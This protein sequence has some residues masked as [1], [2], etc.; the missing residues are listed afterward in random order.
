VSI[1]LIATIGGHLNSR[2]PDGASEQSM[3]DLAG[4]IGFRSAWSYTAGCHFDGMHK[5]LTESSQSIHFE[6]CE[7]LSQ[8]LNQAGHLSSTLGVA[9]TQNA[10]RAAE[11]CDEFGMWLLPFPLLEL[12]A[13]SEG[14][15]FEHLDG[16]DGVRGEQSSVI[17]DEDAGLAT[18]DLTAGQIG[19]GGDPR[20]GR[21]ILQQDCIGLLRP[22]QLSEHF[23][24]EF[25]VSQTLFV[26]QQAATCNLT[27][28]RIDRL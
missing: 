24:F 13:E 1:P 20:Q 27:L 21:W 7:G 12:E 11:I 15:A 22:Q 16:V 25:N 2:G 8:P 28:A 17:S 3:S 4:H 5:Y 23:V 18:V 10:S 9:I 6:W 14:F 19:T 26:L